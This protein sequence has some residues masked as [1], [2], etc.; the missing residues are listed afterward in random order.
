MLLM[1]LNSVVLPEP[2][3]PMKPQIS[4]GPTWKETPLSAASAPKRTVMPR[5]SSKGAPR[6]AAQGPA[7]ARTS[8]QPV[9]DLRRGPGSTLPH[10]SQRGKRGR[11]QL[12]DYRPEFL[13]R[14]REE[15]LHLLELALVGVVP[16]E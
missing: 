12:G 16:L 3:G 1:Q 14:R 6:L 4:P 11:G 9:P 5:A 10:S 2:F 7:L 13:G 15:V 8:S